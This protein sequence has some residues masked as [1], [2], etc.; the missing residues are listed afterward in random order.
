MEMQSEGYHFEGVGTISLKPPSE[1]LKPF[2]RR[3]LKHFS[4]LYAYMTI[5]RLLDE[6][7]AGL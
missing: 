4:G 6:L 7:T 2:M 1:D 3:K 5:K